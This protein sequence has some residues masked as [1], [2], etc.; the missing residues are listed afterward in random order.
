VTENGIVQW[1]GRYRGTL[2]VVLTGGVVAALLAV[3]GA[4]TTGLALDDAMRDGANTGPLFV[5]AGV[6]VASQVLRAAVLYFR[7]TASIRLGTRLERDLR[8]DLVT[9]VLRRAYPGDA[10]GLVA[11][12]VSDVRAVRYMITPGIDLGIAV[13]AFVVVVLGSAVIWSPQLVVAPLI[14]AV[15]FAIVSR[16]QLRVLSGSVR[17]A[18]DRSAGMTERVTEA[19]DNLEAVRDAGGPAAVW[20]KVSAAVREHRD[21][22]TRQGRQESRA[23]L[24]LLLGLAQGVGFG[25]ALLLA[26]AGQLTVGDMVGYHSL[27]LLL[28]APTFAGG[29]AFPALA[30]GMAALAR[31]RALMSKVDRPET[32]TCQPAR[33][34]PAIDVRSAVAAEGRQLP[35]RI[36][37]TLP[38]RSLV[39]VT[40]PTG[41]GKS[42]LLR[43]LAGVERP[44]AGSVHIGRADVRDWR[45]ADLAARVVLVA[46]HD[47]LFSM[48]VAR[49]VGLGRLAASPDEVTAVAK[50][51]GV[52]EFAEAMPERW[53]TRVGARGNALSGGQR[54][55]IALARALLSDAGVL[56]LDDPFSAL[57][58]GMARYLATEL[59]DESRRRTVVVVSDRTDLCARATH[60]LHLGN[61]ELTVRDRVRPDQ[62]RGE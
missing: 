5:V 20:D 45:R 37:L 48:S 38:P 56:L 9:T 49:N 19:L 60:V 3:V 7:Q 24:F 53:D 8:H 13:S 6:L 30:G 11:T 44:V 29:A 42:S 47:S 26:R 4:L 61:A 54:Q 62:L 16:R 23:P 31:I 58:A 59:I 40:G 21:A 41:S 33:D 52:A 46:D 12:I 10:G 36:S 27:L 17:Q 1:L 39:V 18:R 25:H 15:G 51:A 50:R 22:V 43:L 35:P 34:V 32:G 2:L 28:G 55:R 57:D 14:Y